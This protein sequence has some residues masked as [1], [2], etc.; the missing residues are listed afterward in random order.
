MYNIQG[1]DDYPVYLISDNRE[2]VILLETGNK[3]DENEGLKSLLGFRCNSSPFAKRM[4]SMFDHLWDIGA[5]N[6]SS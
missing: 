3:N 6:C 5:S 4:T 1:C 2:L